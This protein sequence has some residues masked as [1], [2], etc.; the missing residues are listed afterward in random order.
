MNKT[1]KE[2]IM[3]AP[4]FECQGGQ[5][6][7][8]A[9]GRSIRYHTVT[10]SR[11]PHCKGTQLQEYQVAVKKDSR[12]RWFVWRSYK[13]YRHGHREQEL[14]RWLEAS[15]LRWLKFQIKCYL[16]K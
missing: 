11:C 13:D 8:I 10:Y 12:G 15:K 7:F 16:E 1:Q 14:N 5:H 4:C 9:F 6:A 2:F 3:K